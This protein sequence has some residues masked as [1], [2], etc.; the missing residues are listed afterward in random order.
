M[1]KSIIKGSSGVDSL[2]PPPPPPQVDGKLISESKGKIN[3]LNEQ[4]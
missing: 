1:V 3:V 2:N 4:F